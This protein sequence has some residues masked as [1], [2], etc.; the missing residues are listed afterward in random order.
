[1]ALRIVKINNM[2]VI[3]HAMTMM[4]VTVLVVQ[5]LLQAVQKIVNIIGMHA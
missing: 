1:M 4:V 2:V 5:L 3:S